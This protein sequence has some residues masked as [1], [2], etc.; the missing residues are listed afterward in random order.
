MNLTNLFNFNFLKENIKRSKATI[1]L[2]TLLVPVIN[3]IYFLMSYA[4]SSV[5]IPEKH[6]N[7][8]IS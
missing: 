6:T 3:V 2:L 7:L 1:L 5:T 4:N 8:P